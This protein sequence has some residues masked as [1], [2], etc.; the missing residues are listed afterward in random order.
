[1]NENFDI[2]FSFIDEE[3]LDKCV[4]SNMKKFILMIKK[5]Y[6]E[7]EIKPLLLKAMIELGKEHPDD[8]LLSEEEENLSDEIKEKYLHQIKELTQNISDEE[9]QTFFKEYASLVYFLT[10]LKKYII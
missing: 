9:Y 1:M 10:N 7:P 4:D 8:T 6:K 2:M 3:I 5:I